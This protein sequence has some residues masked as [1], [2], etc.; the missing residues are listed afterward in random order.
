MTR[1][2]R[3][4]RAVG[5]VAVVVALVA[6]AVAV[7]ATPVTA[8][9][10][11]GGSAHLTSTSVAPPGATSAHAFNLRATPQ[12]KLHD[13]AGEIEEGA[14]FGWGIGSCLLVGS[15]WYRID[16]VG[17]RGGGGTVGITLVSGRGSVLDGQ[18]P[19]RSSGNLDI[20]SGWLQ[21]SGVTSDISTGTTKPAGQVDGPLHIDVQ[22]TEAKGYV[23]TIDGFLNYSQGSTTPQATTTTLSKLPTA[24]PGQP[25]TYLATV[26]P[27]N[28]GASQTYGTFTFRFTGKA[29]Q[30]DN[31]RHPL[32]DS[33]GRAF[34]T[35]TYPDSGT[36]TVTASFSGTS[37]RDSSSATVTQEVDNRAFA[38]F[39]PTQLRFAFQPGATSLPQSVTVSA[40]GRT[41]LVVTG[42]A[43]EGSD[44]YRV[45]AENC[46]EVA[47]PKPCT[48]LV[49]V[50]A[51]SGAPS[52]RLVI[53]DN[54]AN[55][56]QVVELH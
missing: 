41:K 24:S 52:G 36:F 48:I 42:V 18:M 37:T 9:A 11:P 21:G 26:T 30:A 51:S 27:T 55:S 47:A 31:C 7:G 40:L 38:E 17:S 25:V 13:C 53:T 56:P 43:V 39:A 44:D 10:S 50:T 15:P 5:A 4:R 14:K 34:C 19:T 35:V 16:W 29:R 49:T 28:A 32:E 23:I 12:P 46:T 20:T 22:F 45:S 33:S 6:T 1:S 54:A 2:Q 3:A 8:A